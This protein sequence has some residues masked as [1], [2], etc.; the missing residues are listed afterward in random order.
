MPRRIIS[1]DKV[2]NLPTT[3]RWR[4]L[5]AV[6]QVG[7]EEGQA[8]VEGRGRDEKGRQ[9]EVSEEG[10]DRRRSC[11]WRCCWR[12]RWVGVGRLRLWGDD[13]AGENGRKKKGA[14]EGEGGGWPGGY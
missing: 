14:G 1:R 4:S 13:R 3:G 6:G 2:F 7:R 5:I 9:E 11:R 12:R 8:G 10:A